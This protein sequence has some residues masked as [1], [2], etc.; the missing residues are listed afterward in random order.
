MEVQ[1]VQGCSK[2]QQAQRGSRG[3]GGSEGQE[4]QGIQRGSGGSEGKRFGRFRDSG[5]SAVQEVWEDPRFRG[6]GV[7]S[8]RR[9]E[10]EGVR[11]SG[12]RGS[13]VIKIHKCI[14]HIFLSFNATMYFKHFQISHISTNISTT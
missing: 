6:S 9:S 5:G 8:F 12:V 4:V 3:S 7:Q 13:G 11:G 2:V 14:S 1:E 10:G